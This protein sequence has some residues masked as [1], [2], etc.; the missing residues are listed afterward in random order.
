MNT[1]HHQNFKHHSQTQYFTDSI[2]LLHTIQF[3]SLNSLYSLS[4][5]LLAV[6]CA[7]HSD[8]PSED[9]SILA[10]NWPYIALIAFLEPSTQFQEALD[11]P[12]M[13]YLL[14]TWEGSGSLD[15]RGC[16]GH[17]T[18]RPSITI[19]LTD[20][21]LIKDHLCHIFSVIVAICD[22][23]LRHNYKPT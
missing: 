7:T 5:T 9:C 10:I 11:T 6:L 19:L 8:S 4:S 23:F 3:L 14:L 13:F 1:E 16:A 21:R 17:H 2:P 18:S 15:I 12:R 22:N 20:S